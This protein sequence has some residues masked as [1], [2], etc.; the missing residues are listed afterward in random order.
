MSIGDLPIDRSER[1]SHGTDDGHRRE[2]RNI[3]CPAESRHQYAI[4]ISFDRP[5]IVNIR[6]VLW[7]QHF[8]P[9][10]GRLHNRGASPTTCMLFPID[11]Q[12]ICIKGKLEDI[13][14]GIGR[15]NSLGFPT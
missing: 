9:A 6:D 2:M 8:S 7:F 14:E 11:A 3:K 10:V 12:Y 15:C 5:G 4:K 1:S 13:E